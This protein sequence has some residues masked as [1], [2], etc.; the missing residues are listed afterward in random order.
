MFD[1]ECLFKI[2]MRVT[3]V[4]LS[5]SFGLCG[6]RHTL[7]RDLE[8]IS[9]WWIFLSNGM[10]VNR[11]L[12]YYSST[13]SASSPRGWQFVPWPRGEKSQ[14]SSGGIFF[15]WVAWWVSI[16]Q[17]RQGS[18]HRL[19]PTYQAYPY[20]LF[21]GRNR[22]KV[23]IEWGIV[24]SFICEEDFGIKFFVRKKERTIFCNELLTYDLELLNFLACKLSC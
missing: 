21:L 4:D 12:G 3:G 9:Q 24:K 8:V 23:L 16:S 20:P 10:L 14:L 18:L 2:G 5:L 11:L 19:S 6:T 17:H 22:L 15:G 13:M 7:L 1:D